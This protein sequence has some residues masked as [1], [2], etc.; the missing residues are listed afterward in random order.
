MDDET[1]KNQSEINFPCIIDIDKITPCR[2]M[3]HPYETGENT[4][5]RCGSPVPHD[6]DSRVC[7]TKFT[8]SGGWTFDAPASNFVAIFC[9][10]MGRDVLGFRVAVRNVDDGYRIT[11]TGESVNG[12]TVAQKMPVIDRRN[13]TRADI[14]AFNASL[15]FFGVGVLTRPIGADWVPHCTH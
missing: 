12:T 3:V 2:V 15:E 14:A 13:I 8:D 11:V 6:G 1:M 4:S 5:R 9:E 10:I 7:D